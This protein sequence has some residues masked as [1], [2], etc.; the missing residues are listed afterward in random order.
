MSK[1]SIITLQNVRNYG[2]VLQALATQK[3]FEDLGWEVDF[4]NYYKPS[5]ATVSLRL[6]RWTKG[7]N[8]IKKAI[9]YAILL[10]SFMVEER[11]FPRF[12]KKYL[13]V[14]KQRVSSHGDFAKLPLDSDVYCTGSDQTWNST[15]N[16]GVLPELFLDFVPTGKKKIAYA[17][18]FGK[19]QLDGKEIA[20]TRRLIAPYAAISVR[21]SSAVDIVKGLGKEATLVLDPTLQVSRD[22]WLEKFN[23]EVDKEKS[24]Y[25]LIYQLNSNQQ[26][27]DFAQAFAKRRGLRLVRFC[28]RHYQALRPGKAA[29]IPEV[30]DFVRLI[31]NASYVIT[32]SFHATAFSINLNTEMICIYPH[33]FGGRIESILNLMGLQDRHLSSYDDFAIGDRHVDFTHSNEVLEEE[34]A[35][36]REFLI[37]A[38]SDGNNN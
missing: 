13:H 27:D 26:F 32:D 34:R 36:G 18:S 9:Y 1:I 8:P 29:I 31:A 10:P 19:K 23:I 3:V 2:S 5:T 14:Q 6:K 4:F 16:D 11:V 35:K 38:L 20:V 7:F 28:I 33:E 21:E 24:P 17:A 37:K 22:F 15:W 25:V 12:L 30:E